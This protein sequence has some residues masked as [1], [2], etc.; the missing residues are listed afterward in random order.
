MGFNPHQCVK[1]WQCILGKLSSAF[2]TVLNM[3]I[4]SQYTEVLMNDKT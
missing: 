4:L 1:A 2:N 3:K